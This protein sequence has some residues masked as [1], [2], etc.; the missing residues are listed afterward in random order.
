MNDSQGKALCSLLT[1]IIVLL[2]IMVLYRVYQSLEQFEENMQNTINQ[3]EETS[4]TLNNSI[5]DFLTSSSS[6][7]IAEKNNSELKKIREKINNKNYLSQPNIREEFVIE[8]EERFHGNMIK[9]LE[10][11]TE[12]NTEDITTRIERI[13]ELLN[14]VQNKSNLSLKSVG[15]I[16]KATVLVGPQYQQKEVNLLLQEYS[17]ENNPTNLFVIPETVDNKYSLMCIKTVKN[18][19]GNTLSLELSKCK[20]FDGLETMKPFL[21]KLSYPDNNDKTKVNIVPYMDETSKYMIR[22]KLTTDNNHTIEI[23]ND[24]ATEQS[25]SLFSI[26]KV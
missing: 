14:E 24:D 4:E 18:N 5:S 15:D 21:F 25:G 8:E 6:N 7:A 13:K 10:P 3:V 9:T 2:F 12:D 23:I 11:F 20:F 1:I 22:S 19:E 16:F 26:S 17:I